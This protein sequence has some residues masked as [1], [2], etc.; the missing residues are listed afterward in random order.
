[1]E[2]VKYQYDSN[3]GQFVKSFLYQQGISFHKQAGFIGQY[4][5]QQDLEKL[6]EESRA[7]NQKE[8]G[9]HMEVLWMKNGD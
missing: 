8:F 3:N 4:F 1:M 9:D 2:I 6:E 7:W 5:S